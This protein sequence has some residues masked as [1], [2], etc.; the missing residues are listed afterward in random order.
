MQ[1]FTLANIIE[2]LAT[3]TALLYIYFIAQQK[4]IAWFLAFFSSG[5]LAFSNILTNLYFF[6][7][8]NTLYVILAVYGF[9]VWKFKT[10]F[11]NKLIITEYQAKQH[12]ILIIIGV[13]ISVIAVG[14]IKVLGIASTY[15]EITITVFSVLATYL[16]AN[17]ILSSWLYFMVLN[18][19]SVIVYFNVQLYKLAFLFLVYV[20]L[21]II[22]YNKWRKSNDYK[23]HTTK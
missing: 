17:K 18:L 9:Y 14:L 1:F 21:S 22:G 19:L 8:L 12:I 15:L 23:K 16:Q 4:I 6:A 5:L 13:V 7:F 11:N 3:I 10:N 20:V 2:V